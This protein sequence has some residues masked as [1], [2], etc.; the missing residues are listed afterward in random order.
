MATL[1]TAFTTELQAFLA[2]SGLAGL[3][4]PERRRYALMFG[5]NVRQAVADELASEEMSD[6]PADLR[7]KYEGYFAPGGGGGF[8]GFPVAGY[9]PQTKFAN[10]VCLL[11][12]DELPVVRRTV[13]MHRRV[14]PARMICP[15]TG[16]PFHW[17][18][19]IKPQSVRVTGVVGP[20]HDSLGELYMD[21][22]FG[23]PCGTV[24]YS[25]GEIALNG[26]V[27]GGGY[28]RSGSSGIR[29]LLAEAEK[30][31]RQYH[32]MWHSFYEQRGAQISCTTYKGPA[33]LVWTCKLT[34]CK[35]RWDGV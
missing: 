5:G 21:G 25:T 9:Y 32:C 27:Y 8:M 23:E 34:E 11:G 30:A 14:H 7:A 28:F 24:D 10:T 15:Y 20:C 12:C 35:T 22:K 18:T 4:F 2:S 1:M 3:P 13:K 19:A 26:A 17:P 29:A 31:H 16:T 6:V 33:K